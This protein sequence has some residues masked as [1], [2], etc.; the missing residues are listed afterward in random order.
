MNKKGKIIT[1]I[2]CSVAVVLGVSIPAYNIYS[3]VKSYNDKIYPTV[4]IQGVDVSG[5]TPAQ[6]KNILNEKF[7]TSIQN[8]KVNVKVN[9]KTYEL[10]YSQMNP[11]YNIDEVVDKAFKYGKS[12][13]IIDKYKLIKNPVIKSSSLTFTYDT[14]PI[15][16]LISKIK[17]EVNRNP[18][19]ASIRKSGSG[20]SITP[21]QDGCKLNE[22]DLK[23]KIKSSIN[24][25][26]QENTASVE[27]QVQTVKANATKEKLQGVNTL[28]STF[29]TNYGSVSSP[30]RATNIQL[31]TR[32]IN[33]LCIMPGDTFS[34][35]GTLGRRTAEK[36]YQA[37]PVDIGKE[38]GMG[39]GGGI[40]Q[41]STTLYNSVL[42]A[43]IK[44]TVRT[45]HSIPS[46]YVP[47]GYDATVDYDGGLDY[48]FK[49]TLSFPV[50]IEGSS[51]NGVETFN[52]YSDKSLLNTTYKVTSD[53]ASSGKE[54]KVYLQAYQNGQMIS[55]DMIVHDKY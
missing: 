42:L 38:T 23:A 16:D 13:S 45:H 22:D 37:A 49:N 7:Q 34:F 3:K 55:N 24:G 41:V 5:K 48:Q 54:V 32:T 53:A 11:K 12:G 36:G 30:G 28:I 18:V 15:D 43:G 21:D 31:A 50:Y 9:G 1:G 46:A 14:K 26:T 27:A 20:F 17:G 8:K 25:N 29:S 2:V 4:K 19:N 44:A 39:L 47:L 35:N 52:I 40:C 10:S 51:D 33:G 6:A